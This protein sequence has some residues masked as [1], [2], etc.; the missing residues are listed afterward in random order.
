[1]LGKLA[2]F[3]LVL[4]CIACLAGFAWLEQNDFFPQAE[5]TAAVVSE[6]VSKQ[7][8][9]LLSDEHLHDNKL[10]YA[11]DDDTSVVTMYLTV[12]RGSAAEN[13]SHSWEEIN[14]YSAYDY[15]EM[16]V[17][18]YQIAGL[19]QVGDENGPLPGELGY[20]ESVP[21]ATVQIRGQASSKSQQK[22]YKIQVK[23]GK[24]VWRNQ[25]TIALNKHMSDHLRFRN[26]LAFDLLEDIPQ[27]LSL[28]T[29]FVHLYV[30]DTTGAGDSFVA[31]FI[32]GLLQGWD[33]RACAES[34]LRQ[35]AEKIG[36]E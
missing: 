27:L 4:L 21:N 28:R 22:N 19:L 12:F 6:A 23:D 7:E 29:Q 33:V 36:G 14:T 13:T 9:H 18:R 8:A 10:L 34:G 24:G 26:K 15:E 5:E 31:G 2:K 30:K 35:A 1:M 3:L 32:W 11:R 16:G 17:D 20:G 25:R